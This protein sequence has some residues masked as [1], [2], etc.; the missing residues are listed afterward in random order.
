MQSVSRFEANLLK[1]LYFFLGREPVEVAVPLLERRIEEPPCLNKV[2][3]QLVQDALAKGC[4]ALIARRGGWQCERYLRGDAVVEGRLWERTL[5]RDLGL[6]FSRH[7]LAF[8]IWVTAHP[9]KEEPWQ[10][11]EDELSP[12]D[13][14]L[15]FFAHEGLRQAPAAVG[16]GALPKARALT[17]HGLCRL[18]YPEDFPDGS[19]EDALDFGPW[20]KGTGAFMLEALQPE[21]AARWIR[22]E[23]AKPRIADPEQMRLLGGSQERVLTA[24]LGAVEQAGRFDLARFLLRAGAAL[25]GPSAT[26]EMW[27]GGLQ[28]AALRLADRA[29]VYQTALALV[30]QF[31]RL[32]GWTRRAR[33]VGYFDDGYRAAQLWKS[34]WERYQG[35]VLFDRA[36]AIIRELD[37]LRQG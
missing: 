11:P 4:V 26:A 7:S 9:V 28:T 31:E 30:G 5:P 36:Q 6:T 29:A 16:A 10:A 19:A 17:R 35:D 27:V 8:L 13:M 1:L 33:S 25:L 14:M 18:A 20:T 2:A 24:Y 3:V 32:R 15:L 21:L 12:G 22:I 23:T 34:D 37:P